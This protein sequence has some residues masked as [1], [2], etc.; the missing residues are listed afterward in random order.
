[1]GEEQNRHEAGLE[2]AERI[3]DLI[4][5]VYGKAAGEYYLEGYNR[6]VAFA[7]ELQ[8]K[9]PDC[10]QRRAY[11]ALIGSTIE[12]APDIIEEDFPGEDSAVLFLEGVAHEFKE[13]KD[14]EQGVNDAV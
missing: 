8:H 2:M 9:Y 6:V 7:E 1:M 11:H 10:K 3:R 12:G 14:A 13:R 4:S 5:Q